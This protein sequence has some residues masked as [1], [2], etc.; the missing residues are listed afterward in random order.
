MNLVN[1]NV[2]ATLLAGSDVKING[3]QRHRRRSDNRL[4]IAGVVSSVLRPAHHFDWQGE[5]LAAN[6]ISGGTIA[7]A[8]I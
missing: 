3:G 5:P 8:G 4:D 7:G 6:T 1:S 2:E